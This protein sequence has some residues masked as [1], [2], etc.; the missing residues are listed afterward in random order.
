MHVEVGSNQNTLEEAE[1]S[2]EVFSTI[3][4]ETLNLNKR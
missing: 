4:G 2:I 1:R 3:L